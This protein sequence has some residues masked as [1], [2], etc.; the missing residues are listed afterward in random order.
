MFVLRLAAWNHVQQTQAKELYLLWSTV[1]HNCWTWA[2]IRT[3]CDSVKKRVHDLYKNQTDTRQSN[4]FPAAKAKYVIAS[5]KLD[6][7]FTT[8]LVA[9][10]IWF[11]HTECCSAVEFFFPAFYSALQK[12]PLICDDAPPAKKKNDF[13]LTW[14]CLF[15]QKFHLKIKICLICADVFPAKYKANIIIKRIWFTKMIDMFIRWQ[16]QKKVVRILWSSYKI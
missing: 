15:A 11:W 1:F 3:A 7:L 5:F 9:S 10:H 16:Q 13:S 12:S 4:F 8:V 14:Q 6:A 2:H